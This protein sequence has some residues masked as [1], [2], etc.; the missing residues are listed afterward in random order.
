MIIDASLL[1]SDSQSITASAASTNSIDV[2]GTGSP[3]GSAIPLPADVALANSLPIAV[4]VTQAFNNLTSLAIALQV[5]P[6]NAT[7]TE[8]ATRTYLAAEL[9]AVGQLNFPARLPI[10]TNKRYVQLNYTVNGT[11]PT[12]GKIFAAIVAGRQS[13]NH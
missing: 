10:G 3:F 2:G 12:T 5:S 11:P 9:A 7:W 13:N 8:V 6:D 4:N 1:L